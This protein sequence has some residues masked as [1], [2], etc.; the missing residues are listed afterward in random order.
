MVS[1]GMGPVERWER[2]SVLAETVDVLVQRVAEGEPLKMIC[3]SRGW[4]YSVVAK[5][6]ATTPDVFRAYE[7]A[8]R[9]A[10]DAMAQETVAIADGASNE[11]VAVAKLQVDTRQKLASKL[12]RERYGIHSQ[13]TVTH[14]AGLGERLRRARERVV[15][16]GVEVVDA[17]VLPAVPAPAAE[18]T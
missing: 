1:D 18:T 3:K 15:G 9:I 12:Y 7:G 10:A 4:P 8:L 11:D 13:V 2:D 5:W 6:V 17:E 16:D 14:E